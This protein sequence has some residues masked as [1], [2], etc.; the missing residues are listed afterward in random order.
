M[1]WDGVKI[2]T[3]LDVATRFL[4]AK[5]LSQKTGGAVR[6]ALLLYFG[7]IGTPRQLVMDP[8]KE[9]Q[10][11]TV[12]SLLDELLIRIHV[13]TPGHPRSHAAIERAHSTMTEQLR[14]IQ[15]E[16]GIR[17]QEAVVAYNHTIHSATGRT[18]IELMREWQREDKL[19]LRY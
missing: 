12:R 7:T 14:L 13:T 8:G 19:I 15:V 6:E 4:F 2:L 18:P 9:F 1:F 16:R 17:G 5:C 3:I 10:N 11:A